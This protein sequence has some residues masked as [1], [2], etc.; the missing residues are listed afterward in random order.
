MHST[1][2]VVRIG[3]RDIGEGKPCFVIAEAGLNHNGDL[4]LALEL[5]DKAL[6]AGADAVK[7]QKRTVEVL[8]VGAVL[9]AEDTRFPSF[10]RTYRQVREHLEFDL[11]EYGQLIA[12]AATRGI[13]FLCTPFDVPAAEFLE[14]FSLPGYKVA[15]HSVTNLPLL[16]RL[17][18]IGKPVIM[19]TGMCTLEEI[20]RAAEIFMRRGTQ[21][22]LMHCVSAYPTP[23]E[24]C[25][26]RMIDVLRDRYHV[27]VGYSGHELGYL[28]T[29]A[30]VARGAALIERHL[31]LARTLEGFDHKLSLE[32]Q[33]FRRMVGDLRAVEETLGSGDKVVSNIESTT[34]RKY[35]VSIVSATDILA[36]Q[37]IAI[38]MLTLKNPG[39][40]M[41]ASSIP[42]VVGR[43]ARATIP[44]DTVIS[45]E[46]FS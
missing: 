46:M 15:S 29:V 10:G 2:P 13:P 24:Q 32:P 26:L 30:A 21:L 1:V 41:P 40:G 14:R 8:A 25:N 18:E 17:A 44:A 31:T 45:A 11:D 4:R 16:E 37:V 36:G 33:E 6:E 20:D 7:F 19:S 28:P 43:R 27:P 12:H 38:E 35:Q 5:I 3:T 39:T 9:D 22:A 34:R 42:S 23:L